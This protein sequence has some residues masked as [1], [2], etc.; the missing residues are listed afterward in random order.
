MIETSATEKRRPGIL[1]AYVGAGMFLVG[2]LLLVDSANRSVE[3]DK[4]GDALEAAHDTFFDVAQ[5]PTISS[6]V[7]DHI[8]K[9]T[10]ERNAMLAIRH[11]G[12]IPPE[13]PSGLTRGCIDELSVTA[14]EQADEKCTQLGEAL[15]SYSFASDEFDIMMDE[16]ASTGSLIEVVAGGVILLAGAGLAASSVIADSKKAA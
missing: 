2:S 15:E 16:V 13:S 14:P 7:F 8:E 3:L 11:R 4:K 9:I 5:D 6:A 10:G 12:Y 1:R